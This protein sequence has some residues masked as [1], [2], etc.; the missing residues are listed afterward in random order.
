M[1]IEIRKHVDCEK[2][3]FTDISNPIINQLYI[4]KIRNIHEVGIFKTLRTRI[5]FVYNKN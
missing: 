2:S 3:D 5:E 1:I 4:R